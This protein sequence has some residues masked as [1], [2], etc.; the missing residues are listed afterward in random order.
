M[1]G[2]LVLIGYHCFDLLIWT[3]FADLSYRFHVSPILTFG[4]GRGILYLANGLGTSL[5][6]LLRLH[7]GIEYDFVTLSKVSIVITLILII[8]YSFIL[9]EKDLLSY[10]GVEKNG[11]PGPIMQ[12]CNAIAASYSLSPREEDVMR[13]MV[14]GRSITRIQDELYLSKGTVNTHLH[15]IYQKLNIHTKQELLDLV[16]RNA[17]TSSSRE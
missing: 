1:A 5:G 11:K 7:A 6:T 9:T 12:A 14:K 3:L 16:E 17:R 13:L 8:T 15:H 2:W 10:K 4:F